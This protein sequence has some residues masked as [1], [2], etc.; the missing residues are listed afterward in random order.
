MIN[1]QKNG[2]Y[3]RCCRYDRGNCYCRFSS[4]ICKNEV[5]IVYSAGQAVEGVTQSTVNIQAMLDKV[6]PALLPVLYTLLMYYLIK[7][8]GVTTY[9]LVLLT[10]IIGIAGSCLGILA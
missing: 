9:W 8:K 7:K 2:Y 6:A 5:D 3:F 4:N 1:Y 10:V